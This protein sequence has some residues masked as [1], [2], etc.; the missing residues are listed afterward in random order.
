MS[1]DR[2]AAIRWAEPPHIPSGGPLTGVGS[3]AVTGTG[4]TGNHKPRPQAQRLEALRKANDV[5]A[6][7]SKLKKDLAAGTVHIRDVLA[8]PPEFAQAER[9]TVVLLALPGYGPARVNKLL[10]KTRIS[11]SKRLGSL[12][13]RQRT[14]L[15]QYFQH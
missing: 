7:R 12:T 13:E 14:E 3:G 5:R 10:L 6:C 8:K 15:I 11:Q 9:L 4:H 2:P 1:G